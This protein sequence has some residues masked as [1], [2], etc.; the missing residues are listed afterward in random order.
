[1]RYVVGIFFMAAAMLIAASQ[2]GVADDGEA[3]KTAIEANRALGQAGVL[4]KARKYRESAEQIART[5]K[6]VEQVLA[7]ATPEEAKSLLRPLAGRLKKAHAMLELQGYSLTPLVLELKPAPDKPADPDTKLEA[8]LSFAKH[9]AP[10]LISRCGRCHINK[11]EGKLSMRSF[12][13]LMEGADGEAVI[14][15]GD[16]S[17]SALVELITAGD[18]PSGGRKLTSGQISTIEKWIDGGAKFDAASRTAAL[19][20]LA[21]DVKIEPAP[22]VVGPPEPGDGPVSFAGHVA[23]VLAAQC[24]GCH[25]ARNPRGRLSMVDFTRLMRGGE[26][27]SPVTAGKG[28]A[29]LLV[30]KLRGQEGARM[31]FE[32]P[33]LPAKT[34]AAIERWINEGAKFDGSDPAQTLAELSALYLAKT[35]SHE[36]LSLQRA[37]LAEKNWKL[38][39]PD[40]TPNVVELA[41]LRLYGTASEAKLKTIGEIAT[42]QSKAIRSLLGAPRDKPLVK[43]GINFF[44]FARRIDYSEFALMVEKRTLPRDWRGHSKFTITDAYVVIVPPKSSD[45][46]FDAIVAQHIAAVYLADLTGGKGPR[47]LVEGLA[48]TVAAKVGTP[49]LR[50]RSAE[51]SKTKR[52][53]GCGVRPDG[54][55]EVEKQAEISRKKKPQIR[56]GLNTDKERS[57]KNQKA[58]S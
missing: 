34:I 43:G 9:V 50:R 22:R 57:S 13:S 48:R 6:L 11:S 23:T 45:E 3:R 54:G 18:M 27:G 39:I 52:K 2:Q 44:V 37:A 21:P 51:R 7:E 24:I 26:N 25:G 41:N 12:A 28:A 31:P 33:A 56:H 38:T 10:I 30:R 29:S 1:M 58:H 4:Y 49:R 55:R 42:N 35:A 5:Q 14:T 53:R 47:W 16:A 15:P 19:T 40:E 20:S 8:A 32:R 36:E 46:E 17:G